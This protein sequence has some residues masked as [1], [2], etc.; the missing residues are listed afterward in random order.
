MVSSKAFLK[1]KTMLKNCHIGFYP[2][3]HPLNIL[4]YFNILIIDIY[5]GK[6]KHNNNILK[7][8]PHLYMDSIPN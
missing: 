4:Q 5:I 7:S 1:S 6:R 8:N 3:W 2:M